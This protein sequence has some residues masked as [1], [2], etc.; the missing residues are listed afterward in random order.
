MFSFLTTPENLIELSDEVVLARAV[1]SPRYFAEILRRYQ[2]PFLRKARTVVYSE[3][4]AE[5][6]VQETF[7]KIYQY[8]DRFQPQAGASFKSW[9]Y[10]ILMNTAF[11]RY[12]KLKKEFVARAPLE[13]EHYESLADLES[14]Q[15][16]QQETRDYVIS[17]LVRL[18]DHFARV[19]SLYY[20]EQKSQSEIAEVEKTSVGAIK[21]RMHRAKL[22][23]KKVLNKVSS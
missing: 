20:L 2:E 10:R 11:T 12:Q 16:E 4:E 1:S 17:V 14:L 15:F 5:D 8:A 13:T 7:M 3:E 18:P 6:I 21:T 22:E 9:G 23:F 19:L